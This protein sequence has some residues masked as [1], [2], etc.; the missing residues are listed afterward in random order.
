M[1]TTIL[2]TVFGSITLVGAV[3]LA[4]K[5]GASSGLGT[6]AGGLV[7]NLPAVD[8][9]TK[10][11]T[12]NEA[13]D[14]AGNTVETVLKN[15]LT[16]DALQKFLTFLATGPSETQVITYLE[17]NFGTSL[18]AQA[19]ASLPALLKQEL[20]ILGHA[21]PGVLGSLLAKAAPVVATQAAQQKLTSAQVLAGLT[22]MSAAKAA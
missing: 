8:L 15:T 14:A 22:A 20:G 17:T 21:V 3:A 18:V 16:G 10:S 5:W 1:L 6:K 12:F 2:A 4:A 19:E 11:D 9:H 7:Q 13:A